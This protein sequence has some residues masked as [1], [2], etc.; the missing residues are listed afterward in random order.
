MFHDPIRSRLFR[1]ARSR[2]PL[3]RILTGVLGLLA[4]A[5]LVAL[6][7][8]AIAAL[9]I[10]GGLFLLV[11][12]LRFGRPLQA[13]PASVHAGTAAPTGTIEGEFT[14]VSDTAPTRSGTRPAR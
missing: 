2:H 6:G 10:G 4:F 9:V 8:F 14:V 1:R 13:A 3:A 12:A 5:V 11:N 7:M